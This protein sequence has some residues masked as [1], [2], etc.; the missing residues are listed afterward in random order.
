[1]AYYLVFGSVK[2]PLMGGGKYLDWSSD[3]PLG[4]YE[5]ESP[6]DACKLAAADAA[7]MGTF[8]AVEGFPWGLEL[9]TPP[10]SR[11]GNSDSPMERLT[12]SLNR[13]DKIDQ[14]VDRFLPRGDD[15]G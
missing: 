14:L 13:L 15:K 2:R 9:M 12:Q 11:F 3:G 5:A 1:M 6:D 8:F 10:G 7:N 4:V